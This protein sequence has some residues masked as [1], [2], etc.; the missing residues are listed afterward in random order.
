MLQLVRFGFVAYFAL[1][2]AVALSFAVRRL[3]GRAPQPLSSMRRSVAAAL[4]LSSTYAA[5]GAAVRLP[6]GWHAAVAAT[7]LSLVVDAYTLGEL[8][9]RPADPKAAPSGPSLATVIGDAALRDA[10][11]AHT[12]SLALHVG[13]TL[14]LLSTVGHN[15]FGS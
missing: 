15:A 1:P 8:A 2:L 6:L 5:I 7:V 3:R 14:V 11:W 12:T 4:V 9:F 13:M 10:L